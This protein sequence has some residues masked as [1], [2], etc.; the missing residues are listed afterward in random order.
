[1]RTNL[2]IEDALGNWEASFPNK[3]PEDVIKLLGRLDLDRQRLD[4]VESQTN[5]SSWVARQSHTNRGF[6]LHNTGEDSSHWYLTSSTARG[7]IDKA[8]EKQKIPAPH[9]K[10]FEDHSHAEFPHGPS[11]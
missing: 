8:M 9:N 3:T 5:G 4:W 1:M 10:A 11:R 7:A 6:R 2:E